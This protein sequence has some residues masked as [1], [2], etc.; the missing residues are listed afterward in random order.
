MCR[1]S[2]LHVC[3]IWKAL[4]S[5]Y[6]QKMPVDWKQSRTRSLY[7]ST[8]N[9]EEPPVGDVPRP[10]S[11]P[12]PVSPHPQHQLAQLSNRHCAQDLS[13]MI[14]LLPLCPWI[15]KGGFCRGAVGRGGAEG[16][17]GHAL[18]HRPLSGRG[19]PR[20]SRAGAGQ[21]RSL[22]SCSVDVLRCLAALRR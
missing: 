14:K 9:L 11:F 4:T 5:N 22:V 8:F 21:L 6:G 20:H 7:I 2:S 16:A 17:A 19:A 15:E 18:H 13:S 3:R 12:A 10:F 1:P